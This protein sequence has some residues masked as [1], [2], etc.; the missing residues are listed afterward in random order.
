MNPILKAKQEAKKISKAEGMKLKDALLAL[1]KEHQFPDWKS[2]KNSLDTF[3]YQKSSPFLTQWFIQHSE[4]HEFRK[5]NGGFLLTYK[6]QYFVASSDYIE[7]LGLD[8]KDPVWEAIG[9][10]VSSSNA[11]EKFHN[12][13]KG[14]A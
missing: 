2:Y 9:H 7:F 3:W 13:Y 6:G 12:Y 1:A 8:P 4:A 5:K 11:L 10:D 14:L